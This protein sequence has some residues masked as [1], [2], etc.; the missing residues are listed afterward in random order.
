MERKINSY[1]RG[2]QPPKGKKRYLE[3]DASLKHIVST[4]HTNEN[5]VAAYWIIL[6]G[7]KF[8]Y[9]DECIALYLIHISVYLIH[10][11]VLAS[12]TVDLYFSHYFHLDSSE[13]V[14]LVQF[15][16]KIF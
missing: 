14:Q 3:K 11:T 2:V 7:Y 13:V 10:I 6:Q 12:T 1:R 8:L 4:Y 16:F 9:I 5:N 15:K